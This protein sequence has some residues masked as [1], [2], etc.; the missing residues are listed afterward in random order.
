MGSVKERVPGVG[1]SVTL[2]PNNSGFYESSAFFNRN[3][4]LKNDWEKRTKL[5]NEYYE[6]FAKP[7]KTYIAD[8]EDIRVPTNDEFFDKYYN[9]GRNILSVDLYEGRQFNTANPLDR[10]K[11]YIAVVEGEIC[12]KGKREEDELSLG[13]KSEMDIFNNDAEYSYVSIN[14]RKSKKEQMANLELDASYRF[15]DIMLKDKETL[16]GLLQYINIPV[17]KTATKGELDISYQKFIYGNKEKIKAFMDVVKKY[18][19][20]GDTFKKEIELLDLLKSKKGRTAVI[21]DGGSY[22]MGEIPL[23]SNPKSVVSTLIKDPELLKTFYIKIE[24]K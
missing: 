16:I 11:L 19:E 17:L 10:F 9:D 14:N 22:Y 18:D 2:T 8:I 20:E 3:D 21:K 15:R 5:A 4:K 1:N 7:L 24:D 12:M 6:V 23:G 13:M